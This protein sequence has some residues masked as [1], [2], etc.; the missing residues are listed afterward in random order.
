MGSKRKSASRT[1]RRRAPGVGR[2]SRRSRRAGRGRSGFNAEKSHRIVDMRECHIL[3]PELF[4][5]VQ[6]LR[7]LL[8]GVLKP[9]QTAEA[10]VT[11]VDQGVDLLLRN[12]AAE[13][14][15]AIEGTDGSRS[16][17]EA[18]AALCRQWGRAGDHL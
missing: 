13:G 9:K 15:T 17:A 18:C 12:V 3:R 5:L 11:V 16:R 14:L 6:P 8:G 10:Q 1:C 7:A 4:A 2:R